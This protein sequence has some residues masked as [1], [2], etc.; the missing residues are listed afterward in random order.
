MLALRTSVGDFT[1]DEDTHKLQN[2]W[3]QVVT[4]RSGVLQVFFS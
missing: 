3:D 1:C 4:S 2:T